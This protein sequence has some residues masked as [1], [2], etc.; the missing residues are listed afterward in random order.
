M[1]EPSVFVNG[2][3]LPL[4]KRSEL[5]SVSIDNFT[6]DSNAKYK[7]FIQGEP[8]SILDI[9]QQIIDAQANYD[10]VLGFNPSILESCKNAKLFMLCADCWIKNPERFESDKKNEISFLTSSKNWTPGHQFRQ[11][12]WNALGRVDKIGAFDTRFIRTPPRIDT[13]DIV[14]KNSK[15]SIIIENGSYDNWITEKLIDCLSTKTI[16]IYFGAPNVGEFFDTNGILEFRTL[17]ELYEILGDLSPRMYDEKIGIIEE[18]YKESFKY[19]DVIHRID[20]EID[21]FLKERE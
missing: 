12:V 9:D 8:L 21:L 14:F 16:P 1:F 4:K 20:D 3:N 18:N 6:Y 13:K 11:Q 17:R 10:L 7:I 2:F 19:H 5:L 15:F